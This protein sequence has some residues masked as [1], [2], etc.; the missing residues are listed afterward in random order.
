MTALW[1]LKA[2]RASEASSILPRCSKLL[3]WGG[4]ITTSLQTMARETSPL[5]NWI[6]GI[7]TACI[8]GVLGWVGLE[9][10]ATRDGVREVKYQIPSIQEDIAEV[11]TTIDTNKKTMEVALDKSNA[12]LKGAINQLVTRPEMEAR[13]AE[14]RVETSSIRVSQSKTDLEIFKLQE[15]AKAR[16]VADRERYEREQPAAR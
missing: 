16:E 10:V 3:R 8:I 4:K 12:E 7:A 9:V 11:A 13:L 2:V 14:I 5:T 15:A 6:V 1:P